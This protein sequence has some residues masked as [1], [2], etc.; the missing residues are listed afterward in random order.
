M[1]KL[2]I[3]SGWEP[4][5]YS[6]RRDR[7]Q[8][9]RRSEEDH[10]KVANLYYE[11]NKKYDKNVKTKTTVHKYH[12]DNSEDSSSDSCSDSSYG[13]TFMQLQ[14]GLRR[15][16]VFFRA[17]LCLKAN[18]KQQTAVAKSSTKTFHKDVRRP[19]IVVPNE[20]QD[21]QCQ[22]MLF[23]QMLCLPWK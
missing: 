23:I 5:L 17:D 7:F 1:L 14:R 13:K 3:H 11:P 2:S 15:T 19:L 16:N 18:G 21:M 8:P 10:S 20:M 4:Q 12:D 9:W 22:T 6:K